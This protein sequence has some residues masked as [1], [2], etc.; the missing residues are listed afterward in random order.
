MP[1][2]YATFSDSR[3]EWTVLDRKISGKNSGA[4]I[5]DV[6]SRA[7]VSKSLVSLVMRGSPYV[8][9]ARRL[10]VL[11]AA[12]E[13]DYRPNVLARGLRAERTYTVG[14]LLPGLQNPFLAVVA[15]SL[16][17]ELV[18]Y[19]YQTIL[20]TEYGLPERELQAVETMLD[21]RVDGLVLISP[22]ISETEI[23]ELA[24]RTPVVLIARRSDEPTV[25]Y[26]IDDG[27]AGAA[28][29]VAHLVELG[30]QR[31]AHISG[32]REEGPTRASTQTD[33]VRCEGYKE[34]M[35][36]MGLEEFIRVVPGPYDEAGGYRATR[37]MLL[38]WPSPTAIFAGCDMAAIGA[39]SAIEEAGLTVP[40]DISLVGYDNSNLAALTRIS[41]TSVAQP[42]QEMGQ[43]AAQ[44]LIQRL[45]EKRTEPTHM[46]LNP[47]L[48]TRRSS[49]RAAQQLTI[50]EIEVS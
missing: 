15:R 46:V 13:L 22:V 20:G 45:E 41:L 6:A 48:V 24:E 36:R 8:S 16:Q 4:T 9:N 37:E 38:D 30:H 26:V 17:N 12:E 27:A 49:S 35:R 2:G 29:A 31:I 28:M 39:L 10:A 43:L 1:P 23:L 7:N 42:G 14:V 11:K 3:L 18:E 44:L 25:D 19:G 32:T 40:Q 50:A 21:R 34:A 33:S 47:V 5:L